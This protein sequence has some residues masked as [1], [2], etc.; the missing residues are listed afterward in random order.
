[1]SSIDFLKGSLP[2]DHAAIWVLT[3]DAGRVR[4]FS[5]AHADG[6]LVE[7]EDLLNPNMRL[8]EG[9]ATS[10]PKGRSMRRSM[11]GTGGSG[12][13]FEPRHTQSEHSAESF[14]KV[15]CEKMEAA[16]QQGKVR[17]IYLLSEPS[18]LGL[19]RKHVNPATKPLIVQELPRDL[20][21]QSVAEIRRALP[22]Q[23]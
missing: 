13:T 23:L 6:E 20:S 17:R 22:Q 5:T 21:R 8:R 18:F 11:Q 19:I 9:D 10:T 12:Q 3:A 7:F 4:I 2:A 15:V 1:M 16:R 14:A